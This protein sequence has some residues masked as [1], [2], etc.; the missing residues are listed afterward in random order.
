MT[1]CFSWHI[2]KQIQTHADLQLQREDLT[3]SCSPGLL[4]LYFEDCWSQE[5]AGLQ[6]QVWSTLSDGVRGEL[7]GGEV[8]GQSAKVWALL[9]VQLTLILHQLRICKFAYSPKFISS[10][11]SLSVAPLGSFPNTVQIGEKPELPGVHVPHWGHTRG[12]TVILC[13]QVPVLAVSMCPLCSV[14]SVTLF[15]FCASCWWFHCVN[16]PHTWCW[17][18]A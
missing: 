13:L 16:G 18:A 5:R 4:E 15:T 14:F 9:N 3:D 2:W 12:H 1:S 8:K 6:M 17:G 11:K 7:S 10:P